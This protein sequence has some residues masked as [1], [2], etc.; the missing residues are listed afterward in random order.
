MEGK[1]GM[2]VNNMVSARLV[3]VEGKCITVSSTE[4]PDL[5]W[6]LRGAGHSFGIVSSL[7]VKAYPQINEGQ[8]WMSMLIFTPDKI[9]TVAEAI[10]KLDWDQGMAIHVIFACPPPDFKVRL[11]DDIIDKSHLWGFFTVFLADKIIAG[12]HCFPMVSWSRRTSKG[13]ILF[14]P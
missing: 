12:S 1:Y 11:F 5:W 6:G 13:G 8:H 10:S 3:T 9:Q 4:N 14:S 7:I 2:G